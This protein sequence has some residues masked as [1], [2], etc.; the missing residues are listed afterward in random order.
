MLERVLKVMS[1]DSLTM[2]DFAKKIGVQSAQVSHVK[3]GRNQVTLDFV[4]KILVAY[5]QIDP[6]WLIFGKGEM[7]RK[8]AQ[9]TD[10]QS[11]NPQKQPSQPEMRSLFDEFPDNDAEK[12]TEIKLT[13]E[14]VSQEK[15]TVSVTT[16]P[17]MTVEKTEEPLSVE[18]TTITE[19]KS[20]MPRSTTDSQIE[21]EGKKE[22]PHIICEAPRQSVKKIVVLYSDKTYEEFVPNA[23]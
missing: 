15:N 23:N 11:N 22:E 17:K 19:K 2:S 12:Q 18:T 10:I 4:T 8:T 6:D 9:S 1:L 20:E 16:S 3:S 7:F 13:E 14:P 21:V 5:P